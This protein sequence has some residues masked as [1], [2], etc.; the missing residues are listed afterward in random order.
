MVHPEECRHFEVVD[1]VCAACGACLHEIVLNGACYY[2]GAEGVVVTNK[3]EPA[4]PVVP[5]ARLR[6]P[7]R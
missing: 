3:P 1:S 4:D 2:C 5:L 7:E 6:K